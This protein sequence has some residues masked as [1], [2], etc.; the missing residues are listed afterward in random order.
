MFFTK[1]KAIILIIICSIFFILTY[2]DVRSEEIKEI[3]GNAQIIDGDTIKINS[4]KIRLYGIDAPEFKQ[5]CKKPYL[6][7][8]FFTFTKDYPCGKISTQKLQKKLIENTQKNIYQTKLMLKM[9]KKAFGKVNLKCHGTLEEKNKF[10]IL[11]HSL[12]S[13]NKDVQQKIF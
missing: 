2:N 11:M 1:R 3:S 10:I 6:T 5:M 13:K 12:Q 4:K 9:K 8:I 7:I